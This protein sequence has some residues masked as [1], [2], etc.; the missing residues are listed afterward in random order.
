MLETSRSDKNYML[1]ERAESLLLSLKQRYPELSQTS[2]DIC[3]IQYN[4]VSETS[5]QHFFVANHLNWPKSRSKTHHNN[6]PK[7]RTSYLWDPSPCFS[8]I[9]VHG[10]AE[11]ETNLAGCGTSNTR[12]LL[13]SPG[14]SS[15]QHR[16]VDRRRALCRYIHEKRRS[17]GNKCRGPHDS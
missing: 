7:E 4:R 9:I 12:E 10:G 13:E 16:C 1:A 15:I 6:N 14:R 5:C 17:V 2:L 3:K 8:M 11:L